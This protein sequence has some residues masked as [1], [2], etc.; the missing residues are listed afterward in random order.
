[1]NDKERQR[2]EARIAAWKTELDDHFLYPTGP[3]KFIIQLTENDADSF[4][5]AIDEAK[6]LLGTNH[7]S[8]AVTHIARDYLKHGPMQR[9][10][11]AIEE[12]K[13]VRREMMLFQMVRLGPVK[14][15]ELYLEAFGIE[16][17][18]QV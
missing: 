10:L 13:R 18:V 11:D 9:A 1:M 5:L 12:K 15:R 14:V 3:Q 7:K 4:Q 2:L 8:K 6:R 17:D 16:M